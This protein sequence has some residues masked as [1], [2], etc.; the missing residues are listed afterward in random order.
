MKFCNGCIELRL[1]E[2][3]AFDLIVISSFAILAIGVYF[4]HSVR[5][6]SNIKRI[7]ILVSH[8]GIQMRKMSENHQTLYT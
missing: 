3:N 5:V 7:R 6:K 2:N 8:V 1:T 4:K